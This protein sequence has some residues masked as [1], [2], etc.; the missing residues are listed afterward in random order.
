MFW[1]R[2]RK[3]FLQEFKT[4]T[5][6]YS[7]TYI[8]SYLPPS[9]CFNIREEVNSKGAIEDPIVL[10]E[11]ILHSSSRLYRWRRLGIVEQIQ[12]ADKKQEWEPIFLQIF[13]D[14]KGE[15]DRELL[16]WKI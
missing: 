5:G 3:Q 16:N 7:Q 4:S 15:L 9:Q 1:K 6:F 8:I 11:I 2:S 12:L 13:K 10:L 14:M